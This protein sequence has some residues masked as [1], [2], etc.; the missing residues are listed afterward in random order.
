MAYIIIISQYPFLFAQQETTSILLNVCLS[1][2]YPTRLQW[3]SCR[4]THSGKWPSSPCHC[5][6]C[7]NTNT[8]LHSC[9]WMLWRVALFVSIWG[10]VL[11]FIWKAILFIIDNLSCLHN[12]RLAFNNRLQQTVEVLKC[13]GQGQ[14]RSFHE[15]QLSH[16]DPY[17]HAFWISEICWCWADVRKRTW[18]VIWVTLKKTSYST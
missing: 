5:S 11:I 3:S 8:S 10:F 7:Q 17:K 15:L 6:C 12:S 1:M 2:S 9:I 18:F 14:N 13:K 16:H 4:L